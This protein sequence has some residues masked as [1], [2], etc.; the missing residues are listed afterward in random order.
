MDLGA[1]VDVA[2]NGEEGVNAFLNKDYDL[3]FMDVRMP[4]L[5]GLEA[6]QRIRASAK[7]DASSV[8]IIAMTANAMHEDRQAT[9]NAGM[10]GHIA[11]PVDVS[12][13]K[14]V[15]FQWLKKDDLAK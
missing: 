13:L 12:E 9:K 11:K 7:H 1:Y 14:S 3:I 8:P 2:D 6:T 10:D 4:I 5:D 15:L